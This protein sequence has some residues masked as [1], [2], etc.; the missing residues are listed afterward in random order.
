MKPLNT[1]LVKTLILF[2]LLLPWV[3][4]EALETYERAGIISKIRY[5]SFN[6]RD[7]EYRLSPTANIQI[8]GVGKAKLRDL[9]NGDRIWFKGKLLNG[10]YYVDT[11]VYSTPSPS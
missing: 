10:V 6:I 1:M 7:Q 8:Q 11:I 4:S 5:S 9:K 3:A 2:V